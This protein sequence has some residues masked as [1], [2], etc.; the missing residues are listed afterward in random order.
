MKIFLCASFWILCAAQL[1][2]QAPGSVVHSSNLGFSYRL[3]ASWAVAD[4]A[5]AFPVV[6][7]DGGTDTGGAGMKKGAACTQVALTARHGDPASAIVVVALP[8][9][10]Y[11]QTMT[12][13][14]LPGFAAGAME[15]L[16]GTFDVTDPVYGSYSLGGHS[17]WIERAEAT[18]KEHP[19]RQDTLEI[20]C[21]VLQKSTVCWMAVMTNKADLNTFEHGAVTL[22]G[23]AAG[24]LIPADAFANKPM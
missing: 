8:F 21:G 3:P 2:A 24:A 4:T 9:D 7:Q 12:A 6:K 13:A 1:T 10:C 20:T 22:D 14:D 18:P 5:P 15:G 16:K 23:D 11:G 17:M 19:E